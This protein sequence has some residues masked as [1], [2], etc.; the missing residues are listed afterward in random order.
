MTFRGIADVAADLDVEQ[1]VVRFWETRF[2]QVRPVRRN[3]RRYYRPED[4]ALLKGIRELLH[5]QRLSIEGA[6]RILRT[7]GLAFVYAAGRGEVAALDILGPAGR[8]ALAAL[9]LKQRDAL[10]AAL[11]DPI[12]CRA[13]ADQ[14]LAQARNGGSLHA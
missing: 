8:I 11:T 3:R 12:V 4:V 13:L 2:P 10:T 9:S 1:H 5:V 14:C 6:Q 7:K